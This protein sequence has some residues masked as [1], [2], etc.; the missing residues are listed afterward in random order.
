M[1]LKQKI[2]LTQI[3]AL[4]FA[5]C[6]C[7]EN[8]QPQNATKNSLTNH[9]TWIMNYIHPIA[10]FPKPG[11]QFQW[12]AHLLRDPKAFSRAI[13]EFADR[14]RNSGIEVIAGLD[15]RG[16]IFGAALAYELKLPFILIRKPGKLPG[17]VEKIDYTLE[18]GTNSF[19]IEKN[20]LQKGQR[21]L[22]IDDVLATGGT[23]AAACALV[24]RLGADVV[25]VAC[26]IELPVLKGRD[27]VPC[28]VFSLISID[29]DE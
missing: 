2:T 14:Y 16:F 27:K 26:L 8:S 22:V 13:N 1:T 12:Y 7:A 18:Y 29:V 10:D 28:P 24:K 5:V 19:E 6:A 3:C 23:A 25:E 4:L 20:S 21:V 9:S 17:N 11:I 15:S